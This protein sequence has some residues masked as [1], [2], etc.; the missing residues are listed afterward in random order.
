MAVSMIY[1]GKL[2]QNLIIYELSCTRI[3]LNL[4]Y[5]VNIE[6]ALSHK[7][8][9]CSQVPQQWDLFDLYVHTWPHIISD[10]DQLEN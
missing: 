1:Y 7:F 8:K 10:N 2:L 5:M 4:E 6:L 9:V 3:T